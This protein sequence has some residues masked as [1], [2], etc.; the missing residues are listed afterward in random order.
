MGKTLR[1]AEREDQLS[2]DARVANP[3]CLA[4]PGVVRDKEGSSLNLDNQRDNEERKKH[5]K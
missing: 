4:I 3:Y 2:N 1:R 5:D